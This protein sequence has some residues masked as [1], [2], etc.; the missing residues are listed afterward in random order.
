MKKRKWFLYLLLILCAGI[1]IGP[2]VWM[3]LTSFKSYEESI[4]IPPTILPEIFTLDSY[5]EVLEK[6]PFLSFYVNTFLVFFSPLW[7][8]W[9]SVLW[10]PMLSQD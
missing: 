3:I 5:R 4:Q 7:W 2:F 6:F 8:S 10:Q 1:T 9:Q